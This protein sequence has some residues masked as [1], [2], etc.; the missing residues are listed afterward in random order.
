MKFE[1]DIKLLI[2]D[3]IIKEMIICVRNASP[4]EACGLIF[5]DIKEIK[6]EKGFQYHY[7]GNKFDCLDSDRKS[8]VAF[9]IENIEKLFEI[10]YNAVN[11]YKLKLI[12][13]FHSHPAGAYPSGVDE[14]NMKFLDKHGFSGFKHQIWSIM[15][16][17]NKEINGFIYY[18]KKLIQVDVQI[19]KK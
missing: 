8:P 10:Y 2:N 7:I 16:A 5:G 6:V 19:S 11:K 17:N 18:K 13:I 4:N 9:L 1:K 3:N 14:R 12:S 15:D